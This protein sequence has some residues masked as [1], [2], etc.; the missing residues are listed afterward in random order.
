MGIE[1]LSLS[2]IAIFS[3]TYKHS[4]TRFADPNAD[5]WALGLLRKLLYDDCAHFTS[6]LVI[7]FSRRGCGRE[8]NI[9]TAG[10]ERQ[11]CRGHQGRDTAG[12]SRRLSSAPLYIRRDG[13]LSS[14]R[15][16]LPKQNERH[17]NPSENVA[18]IHQ[19]LLRIGIPSDRKSRRT[20]NK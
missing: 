4:N 20:G 16:L 2:Y 3:I 15:C 6:P 18:Y 10:R 9:V 19:L 5:W 1:N 17:K 13:L 11:G 12:T 7:D 8:G 14:F